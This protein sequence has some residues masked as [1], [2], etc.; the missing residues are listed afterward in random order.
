[1][2][3]DAWW[4]IALDPGARASADAARLRDADGSPRVNGP[5]E[6]D[7]FGYGGY[8]RLSTLLSAQRPSS[9]VPDERVFIVVHQLFELAFKQM[10]FDL[11]VVSGTLASLV[12]SSGAL[13]PR[14]LHPLPGSAASREGP[15][16]LW[17]PA[18][19]AAGR[20][21][22][23]AREVLPPIMALLGR[24]GDDDVLFSTLEYA[25]FRDALAPASGFQTAQLRLIQ[26]A[27]AKDPVL[28]LRVFPS[29]AF[30]RDAAPPPAACPVAPVGLGD[31]LI[32]GDDHGRAFP[33]H[34]QAA[35]AASLDAHA[36]GVLAALA[37]EAEGLAAPPRVRTIHGEDIERA[38]A[39][40]AA[41]YGDAP[42]AAEAVGTFE[43]DLRA[44]ADRDNTRRDALGDARRG[45]QALLAHAPRSCLAFVLDRVAA[46]DAALHAPDGGS[47]LTA[48]RKAVRRHVPD[49]D[50]GTGGGGMP[51]LVTSQRYL[52]PLFPALVAYGDLRADG[53]DERGDQW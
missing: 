37:P 18:L 43:A 44:A 2:T 51:Y 5:A 11:S 8:L 40:V 49:G 36:H 27:L 25:L 33:Q 34:P 7:A 17:R 19:T 23:T 20:L 35:L 53:A 41:T 16:P 21:R 46:T 31:A 1:M 30:R 12:S 26:R 32:L 47:F 50:P 3:D 28:R 22:H 48:H 39:R 42:D 29:A 38:V 4:D 52:L 10:A 9:S 24:G 13:D 6:A 14:A 15:D 45:A